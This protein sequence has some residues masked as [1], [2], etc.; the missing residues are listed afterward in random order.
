MLSITAKFRPW[1]AQYDTRLY[2]GHTLSKKQL[3]RHKRL[4]IY[5]TQTLNPDLQSF[6]SPSTPHLITPPMLAPRPTQLTKTRI[7][8]TFIFYTNTSITRFFTN[9]IGENRSQENPSISIKIQSCLQTFSLSTPSLHNATDGII[10]L[11]DQIQPLDQIPSWPY[12]I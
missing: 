12:H 6:E 3:M 2:P 7:T 10:Q 1:V 8:I 9:R 4:G 5:T 11:M